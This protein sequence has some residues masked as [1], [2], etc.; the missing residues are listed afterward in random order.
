MNETYCWPTVSFI[1]NKLCNSLRI[2]L[3]YLLSFSDTEDTLYKKIYY[4]CHLRL[5]RTSQIR[6]FTIMSRKIE[7]FA[8]FLGIVENF[9]GKCK[10]ITLSIEFI[11]QIKLGELYSVGHPLY[12]AWKMKAYLKICAK[13]LLLQTKLLE[14]KTKFLVQLIV[15]NKVN[16]RLFG[17]Y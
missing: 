14:T 8:I 11:F 16:G 10:N 2:N 9:F 17:Q 4:Y 1:E 6:L 12:F 3:G 15:Q 5:K 13:T 7:I